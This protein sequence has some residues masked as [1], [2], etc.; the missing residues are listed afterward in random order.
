MAVNPFDETLANID[1]EQQQGAAPSNPFDEV[2]RQQDTQRETSLRASMKQAEATTPD[3]AAE[4]ARLS[5]GTGIAPA[6]VERNFDQI[7]ARSAFENTPFQQIMAQTPAVAEYASDPAK[8]AIVKDDLEQLGAI[9]WLLTGPTRSAARAWH[10]MDV[11]NLRAATLYRELTQEEHDKLN[12]ARFYMNEGGALG[13]GDSWFRK[14]ISGAAGQLP[15]LY[16]A[17]ASGVKR[18]PVGAGVGAGIGAAAGSLAG[19]VGAAPGALSGAIFGATRATAIGA[20]EYAF[21]LEAGLA[22]DEMLTSDKF[23]DEL[24]NQIDPDAAKAA[25][26]G[27]GVINAGLEVVGL[28]VLAS[29]I[30]GIKNLTRAGARQA[31]MAA[32][33]TQT[34]R[35]ALVEAGK[36]YATTVGKETAVEVAQRAVTIIAGEAAKIESGQNIQPIGLDEAAADLANEAVGA[37]QSFLIIGAPGPLMQVAVDT[38]RAGEAAK[39]VDFF[40][41]LGGAVT[42]SKTLERM[43][44][45]LQDF[46]GRATKDGPIERVY[47][48]IDTF[49]TYWQEKGEDPAAIAAELT[50]DRQAYANALRTGEDLAIPTATYAVKVAGTEHNAYFANELRLGPGEMNAREAATFIEEQKAAAQAATEAGTVAEVSPTAPIRAHLAK[51]LDVAGVKPDTAAAYVDLYES[52]FANLAERAGVDPVELYAQYGLTVDRPEL[53]AAQARDPNVQ[54]V[55]KAHAATKVEEGA[56]VRGSAADVPDNP[57]AQQLERERTAPIEERAEANDARAVKYAMD[58]HPDWKPEEGLAPQHNIKAP[59]PGEVWYHGGAK[60]NVKSGQLLF[61]TRNEGDAKYYADRADGEVVPVSVNADN[62]ARFRDLLEVVQE[63]GATPD[64][65]AAESAYDGTNETDYVYVKAVRD[66]LI[67]KGF[68]SVLLADP[69]ENSSIDALIPLVSGVV[70]DKNEAEAQ[71]TEGKSNATPEPLASRVVDQSR[72]PAGNRVAASD[73]GSGKRADAKAEKHLAKVFGSILDSARELDP[74]V[75]EAE[76]RAEFDYRVALYMDQQTLAAESGHSTHSVLRAIAAYGGISLGPNAERASEIRQMFGGSTPAFGAVAGVRGVFRTPQRA[77]TANQRSAG[78]G[79]DVILQSLQ[80]DPEFAWIESIDMLIDQIDEAARHSAEKFEVVLPGTEELRDVNI[81]R[82]AVWWDRPWRPI[83][84]MQDEVTDS[85]IA[86]AQ[87]DTSFDVTE[88]DQSLFDEFEALQEPTGDKL[89]TGEVQ[90]RLPEAG[91]VREQEVATPEVA[92]V[93]FSLTAPVAKPGKK[94]A[95]QKTLFQPDVVTSESVAAFAADMKAIAG[96]DLQSFDLSLSREGDLSL[97]LIVVSRGAQRAGLGSKVIRQLTRFADANGLRLTLTPATPRDGIGTTGKSRLVEFYKRFGFVENKGRNADLS[98]SAGMYREPTMPVAI[99]AIDAAAMRATAA[100]S[101]M[102][103]FGQDPEEGAETKTNK[104]RG[105]IRFGSD[106]QFSITLFEKADL[107]TFL[108]ETGHFYLE[109]FGDLV[110]KIR[111]TEAPTDQQRQAIADY[112]ALLKWFGVE[113]REAIGDAQHEQ[114][115][116]GFEAYLME[117]RAPSATLRAAF[118][119]FRA[120]LIGIYRSVKG[121]RVELTDDVRRVLDRMVASDAAIARAE[122]EASVTPMFTTA[123]E[124]GMSAAEFELY[125]RTVADA[126]AAAREGLEVQLLAEVQ[127][128]QQAEWKARRA[129]IRGMVEAVT[130]D[131]PVY[132]AIAAMQRGKQANGD[133]M[134]EGL[135]TPPLKLSRKLLVKQFG[136]D[137]LKRLPR[138]YIYSA[139]GGMDPGVVAGIFGF[140]SADHMLKAIEE[141][142]PMKAR[143]ERETDRLMLEEHGSMLLDGTLQEKA[144][145]AVANDHREEIIRA[146]LRALAL[147]RRDVAPFVKA[148]QQAVDAEKAERAYERRWFEAEAKL[149]I[150]IAEGRKQVEIDALRAEVTELKAQARGGAATI[151]AALPPV[152]AL[153]EAAR[154]RIAGTKIRELRPDVFW[155]A[156]RKAAKKAIEAA[157]RQDFEAAIIAKQQELLNL[158]LFREASTV[159][160]EIDKRVQKALDLAKPSAR[161]RLGLAGESYL[162]QV[163]ALL[164]QYDFVRAS[165]RALDRR[166]AL[167]QWVGQLQAQGLP[168]EIPDDVLDDARRIHY[169]EL[170][171]DELIGITDAIDHIVHLARLKNR[172]L[173]TEAARELQATATDLASSIREHFT[174][175]RDRSIE[176]R[177]PGEA[178]AR[179]IAGFFAAHRKLA[180]LAREMDGFADGGAMW[181]AIVRPLNEAGDREAAMNAEATRGLAEIVQAAYPGRERVKLYEK[182]HIPAIGSSLSK[183]GRLMVALNWGNEGNRQR[184][185]GG[186]GWN[187]VQVQAILD[188]LDE[189]D[190]KFVQGTWDFIDGYWSEIEAKQ[191][192]VTGVAPAKV[193]AIAVKT[194]FGEFKGGYFPIK[195]DDRQSAQAGA[196]LDLEAGNLQKQAA[197]V[198]A[199]TRRGHTEARVSKVTMPVRLDFGVLFEHVQQVIHD[200][201]HHEMLIDVGRVLGHRDVQKAIYETYGDVV[202]RQFKDGLRDVAFGQTPAVTAFEKGINHLRSGAT[203]AGLGWNLTTAILQ[204]LGLTQS[205]VRIGPKWVGR[206]MSRWLRDAASMENTVAWINERS[207]FMRLRGQTQQR[208]INEIRNAV[209]VNTGKF[210]GWVDDIL[211]TTT[212][213]TVGRQGV[214]DSF[215][216]LIQQ[217]QRVADVPTWLGQYEKAMEAGETE[218][219]AIA[220]ADQAVLDAQGGGQIKDL[221]GVQRGGPLLKLWTN[222]YSFFNTTYNLTV[223]ST[224]RTNFRKPGQVGRLAVDYLLLYTIPASLGYL[225]R[226]ALKPGDDDESL[227]EGLIRDN[228]GYLMGTL[229]GVR[230]LS[231]AVQ[232][233]FGYEG[234]AGARAF[235]TAARLVKQVEQGEADAAFWRALNDL[236]GIIFHYPSGQ[237]RRTIEGAAALAEGTTSNPGAV[238]VGAPSK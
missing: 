116:R 183:M 185:R 79:I 134:V 107:S 72:S 36:L 132:Q 133:P 83:D 234:P 26:I 68:D 146:E 121:L 37:F 188:T 207:E 172:L 168:V 66:A 150:A 110:E 6:I 77:T 177:L 108:H 93:P 101:Q 16:G 179:T 102:A 147:R 138:P 227:V 206:G 151:N 89:T 148:G 35:A 218:A 3:R 181:E 67:A 143:I 158:A 215:F 56:A 85:M 42:S 233:Y 224:R 90:P 140:S 62:P 95:G 136:E 192:R 70:L 106:R 48:P 160:T 135:E 82:E 14:A 230:E 71:T 58:M 105:A 161:K 15:I 203:I 87:G 54:R 98:L 25:A 99:P 19:G 11:A 226:Q 165:G 221:A 28:E 80:A 94:N 125:R 167:R 193:E 220:L 186:Y 34:G 55:M 109:V 235:A 157:A 38:Q 141:A 176:T 152:P 111:A 144:T 139:E 81:R 202:Y 204:P 21:Q 113:N 174:G 96:P 216:F 228:L 190:W 126:S 214:A 61:I 112:D 69:L 124:A 200:L 232:G 187:D 142:E 74:N 170:T 210:S 182:I 128:E 41:A 60:A 97:N 156:S 10:Q 18:A 84:L 9:E 129:E 4:V 238:I 211:K 31:T 45:A 104:R 191:K 23:R 17:I 209:G 171:V 201:S 115:A 75:N 196:H 40:K 91:D 103:E 166:E 231:G 73:P 13:V 46:I 154:V 114:F 178:T 39:N 86:E 199:T 2:I 78:Y 120:W 29:A 1:E 198:K 194:R 122:Q 119:R 59:R 22:L 222:F 33:R 65:I 52:T 173:K 49:T 131:M 50:G 64:D 20:A 100:E 44:E 47:A 159:K 32:L 12:T 118:A 225:L 30:P 149:R 164:D 117:G 53:H 184:I 123:A 76:L 155:N 7:K 219:R 57:V 153:R 205:M 217:M 180:S 137:R 189:R 8:L 237:T 162:D 175:K 5:A 130:Y 197:Y 163:D 236:A 51:Q 169:R 88:F 43:P 213:N 127:R 229:L 208:E 27:I 63:V 223:E 145:A 212:L 195:Y 92:E 24:G